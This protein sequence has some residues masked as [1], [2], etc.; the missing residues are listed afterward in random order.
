MA[1][2]IISAS[3]TQYGLIINPD[4]SIPISGTITI[5][6]I[7]GSIVIGSVS[8]SVDSV[9]I[10]SGDNINLGNAWSN[11]GSV[12]TVNSVPTGSEQWIKNFN[13]LGSSV[14]VTNFPTSFPGS[15]SQVTNP[16]IV[17]GSQQI[18]NTQVPISGNITVKA[19]SVQVY[20]GGGAITIDG[21]VS[22]TQ[23]TSPWVVSGNALVSGTVSIN[24]PQSIGS[25]TGV[26]NG[27]VVVTNISSPTGS[28]EIYQTTNADMQVQA[29]QETTPWV[30][31]GSVVEKQ[32]SPKD[33]SKNNS[34]YTFIYMTSGTATGITGSRIGSIVQFI[35][36]GSYVQTLTYSNDLIT[37]IGSWV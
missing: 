13:E 28:I 29:T 22:V 37:N 12:Y 9:Y 7:T 6:N 23:T 3:G 30:I 1:E 15:V 18:T 4:G 21:A 8:A 16:W 19:G 24:T 32:T 10:Q 11:V 14:V 20:D 36:T 17:L 35:G 2:V 33:A 25:W 27:S 5:T 26:S 34:E 31:A